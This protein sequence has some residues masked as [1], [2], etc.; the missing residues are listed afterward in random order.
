MNNPKATF[1]S[2]RA[3][4]LKLQQEGVKLTQD[5]V[6]KLVGGSKGTL[7]KLIKSNTTLQEL[8]DS[9]QKQQKITP[10][11]FTK[12]PEVIKNEQSSETAPSEATPT[13]KL[14]KNVQSSETVPFEKLA[15]AIA[16]LAKRVDKIEEFVDLTGE[17][18]EQAGLMEQEQA[19][20]TAERES[21]EQEQT[22][23]LCQLNKTHE[24]LQN[25]RRAFELAIQTP[26]IPVQPHHTSVYTNHTQGVTGTD[27]LYETLKQMVQSGSLTNLSYG[28]IREALGVNNAQ[29]KALRQ[30][31]VDDR[32]AVFDA[33]NKC[34]PV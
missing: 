34:L 13:P 21:W 24:A 20:F 17:K 28:T 8:W 25:L 32:L 27:G 18:K 9:V 22:N 29:A 33:T 31:L 4:V 14:T 30:Q 7:G 23:I 19:K 6:I 11:K 12:L 15:S 3:C 26:N 10:P 16:E 1:D 5:N 2:V